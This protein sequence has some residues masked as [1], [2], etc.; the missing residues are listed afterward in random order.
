MV[1]S[2]KDHVVEIEMSAI[3]KKKDEVVQCPP[4][5]AVTGLPPMI[6]YD[7]LHNHICCSTDLHLFL[8]AICLFF[9]C[10]IGLT[11]EPQQY[12]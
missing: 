4:T 6:T 3:M 2:D 7:D 12:E 8:S 9:C 11:G 5:A 10:P 1:N